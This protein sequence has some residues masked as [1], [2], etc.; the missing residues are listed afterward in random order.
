MKNK[1]KKNPEYKRKIYTDG[2]FKFSRHL[3]YF[4]DILW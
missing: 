4:G 3:N 1:W 2:F